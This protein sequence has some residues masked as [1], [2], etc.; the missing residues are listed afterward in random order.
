MIH[1]CWRT[2]SGLTCNENAFAEYSINK[3]EKE[4]SYIAFLDHGT[5]R[6]MMNGNASRLREPL[7]GGEHQ[8][9]EELAVHNTLMDDPEEGRNHTSL[10]T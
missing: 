1:V 8:Q 2:T 3:L 6:A 5:L 9:L 4:C 10:K 7:G